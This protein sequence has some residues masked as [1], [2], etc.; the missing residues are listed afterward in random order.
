MTKARQRERKR[1]QLERHAAKW[2][3]EHESRRKI[4]EERKRAGLI[5][6]YGVK[7]EYSE[8]ECDAALEM[9]DREDDAA[10]GF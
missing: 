2:Q 1:T 9:L 8:A 4:F 10:L 6:L 3:R 7:N 5:R